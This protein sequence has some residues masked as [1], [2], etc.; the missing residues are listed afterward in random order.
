[1]FTNHQPLLAATVSNRQPG[2][3]NCQMLALWTRGWKKNAFLFASLTWL[4]SRCRDTLKAANVSDNHP[5]YNKSWSNHGFTAATSSRCGWSLAR[6]WMHQVKACKA[7]QSA[8]INWLAIRPTNRHQLT[9]EPSISHQLTA[10]NAHQGN[11]QTVGC[12]FLPAWHRLRRP[13]HFHYSCVAGP[14][15]C[16]PPQ[17]WDG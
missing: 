17:R 6:Q 1:M 10:M 2:V 12:W 7:I 16:R 8:S 3:G 5:C 13:F 14:G 15:P 9:N 11:K 4:P